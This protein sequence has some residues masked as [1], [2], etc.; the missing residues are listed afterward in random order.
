MDYKGFI[1]KRRLYFILLISVFLLFYTLNFTNAQ[2]LTQVEL[3]PST[4]TVTGSAQIQ[5]T[6]NPSTPIAGAQFDVSFDPNMLQVS[7]V[8]EGNLL[9][10]NGA[11]T[12]FQPGTIDNVLGTVKGITGVITTSGQSVNSQ[13]NLA[14]VVF[15]VKQ[16]TQGSTN[17]QVSN[18]VVGDI[19]GNS[20]QL[21]VKSSGIAEINIE[22][23]SQ[24]Y[25]SMLPVI[26]L[27]A[28]VIIILVV[29]NNGRKKRKD[30][31]TNKIIRK[32]K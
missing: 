6:I 1:K 16:N 9:S 7:E 14:S 26:I 30:I 2:I 15:L 27:I 13:G 11:N 24:P 31:R 23:E 3:L 8:K 12:F 25:D 17:V 18:V 21:D 19:N 28:V 32:K 22:S 4:Q 10:Q 5:L 20:L 29:I